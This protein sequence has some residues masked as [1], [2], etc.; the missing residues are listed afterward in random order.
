MK[1]ILLGDHYLLGCG[2]Q[3]KVCC[4][5]P[6]RRALYDIYGIVRAES[7][8]AFGQSGRRSLD[9]SRAKQKLRATKNEAYGRLL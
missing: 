8:G 2:R 1:A 3:I 4:Q 5:G 7:G 9:S 6:G